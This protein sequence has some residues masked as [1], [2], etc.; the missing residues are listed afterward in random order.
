MLA[1]D[2]QDGASEPGDSAGALTHAIRLSLLE[3]RESVLEVGSVDLTQVKE[4]LC[5]LD[6]VRSLGVRNFPEIG[7]FLWR[8][9]TFKIN[10]SRAESTHSRFPGYGRDVRAQEVR[11]VSG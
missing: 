8:D 4:A 5:R 9:R 3:Q 6:W 2:M 11:L 10:Q 7:R 1:A